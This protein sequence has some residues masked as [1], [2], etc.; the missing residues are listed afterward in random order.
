[1][2][3]GNSNP[4]GII[5]F[6]LNTSNLLSCLMQTLC[7]TWVNF[8]GPL[9][10]IHWCNRFFSVSLV[11]YFLFYLVLFWSVLFCSL[12]L[13]L[14]LCALLC[15]VLFCICLMVILFK[16]RAQR[17]EYAERRL[18]FCLQNVVLHVCLMQTR[19]KKS[20]SFD[21]FTFT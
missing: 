18:E 15:F 6:E 17:C 10:L 4:I 12:F 19:A 16:A 5:A 7:N 3:E 20:T 11:F 2:L 21:I 8:P 14:F 1:M 9:D 13:V